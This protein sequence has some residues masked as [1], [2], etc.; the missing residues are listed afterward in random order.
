MLMFSVTP[1]L[2]NPVEV[3]LLHLVEVAAISLCFGIHQNFRFHNGHLRSLCILT[4]Y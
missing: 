1:Q 4:A 3:D 2:C